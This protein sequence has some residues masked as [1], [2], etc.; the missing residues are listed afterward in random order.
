MN[1]A[2]ARGLLQAFPDMETDL[3]RI[4]ETNGEYLNLIEANKAKKK[5]KPQSKIT[6]SFL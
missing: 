4:I 2:E 5:M 3:Q 6:M 1:S